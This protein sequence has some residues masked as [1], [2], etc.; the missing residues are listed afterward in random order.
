MDITE[1]LFAAFV[2]RLSD[3]LP[4]DR[5]SD[6]YLERVAFGTDASCYQ[7][8]PKLVLRLDDL[9]ELIQLVQVAGEFTIPLTF[10]AAGTSLSGQA[11]TDS[12]LVVLS[13]AWANL[14]VRD[15]GREIVLGPAVVGGDANR[16]LEKYARKIGPDPASINTAKMGGIAANNAS[17]MC[18]GTRDNAYNTLRSMKLVLANG[19]C[20]D[21]ACENSINDFRHHNAALLEGLLT[22]R[23]EIESNTRLREKIR[24]KYRIKNT[25]GYGLNALLDFDDPIDILQHLMI[26]S[27]GT[28]GFI[29]EI[30]LATVPDHP[31]KAAAL[32]LFN[33]VTDAARAVGV[34]KGQWVEAVELMDHH[35]LH[36]VKERLPDHYQSFVHHKAGD[37]AALLVVV[38]GETKAALV[39]RIEQIPST[40][41]GLLSPATFSVDPKEYDALWRIRKSILPIVGAKRPAGT[42][43]IIEDVAFPVENLAEAVAE[44]Q[45]L[46]ERCGYRD[47]VIFGH[48][49]A[50]NLHIV[51]TQSFANET[52]VQRYRQLMQSLADLVIG[53]YQGSMKAEHGTGRN[54]APFVRQEWGDDAYAIMTS[55]KA[56]LDPEKLL[57]PDVILSDDAEL[58]LRNLKHLPITDALVD[59][60]I[61]CGFC[62]PSCPSKNLTLSPRQR[63]SV[64]RQRVRLQN[65]AVAEDKK[66]LKKI[67]KDYQYAGLDTCAACGLCSIS[68]PVGINTGDLTRALRGKKNQRFVWLARGLARHIKW[69]GVL[70]RTMLRSASLLARLVG[71]ERLYRASHWMNKASGGVVPLWLPSLQTIKIV[72][73]EARPEVKNMPSSD[74][75]QDVLVVYFPACPNRF[76]PDA[77]AEHSPALGQVI[78][79]LAEQAGVELVSIPNAENYCCGMPFASK[80]F[81]D[82]ARETAEQCLQ[83]L[84]AAHPERS[85]LIVSDASPCASTLKSYQNTGLQVMDLVEFAHDYLLPTLPITPLDET[86]ML[87]V[88]CTTQV[89]GNAEKMLRVAQACAQ[90]V[91]RPLSVSCCGFAGDKGFTLPELNA[92]ALSQ[93]ANEVPADCSRGYSNSRTCELGL[94]QH[95][96]I[97]YEHLL[98]LLDR[99]CRRASL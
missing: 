99:A 95:S 39:N 60:C 26:G 59:D 71:A 96:G 31:Y 47:A 30:R 65:S 8:I 9:D 97:V 51:F 48:A 67:N 25:T 20:L 27:E 53:R 76:M 29:A 87:H 90:R 46:F 28:L 61:E 55:I 66:Q 86:V 62:E 79:R 43:V 3:F 22:L 49:L 36:S 80:G 77:L 57:N 58:H 24:Y 12:V 45:T 78:A 83:H 1:W 35:C 72:P 54:M 82:V 63:I 32:W 73:L 11:I 15:G 17:G 19:S 21:T 41:S 37:I 50:G 93:L 42:T 44:L 13:S 98:Y 68:C 69:L 88:T 4:P 85:L 64:Q 84:A 89:A 52:Q 10:R 14:E 91:V 23:R 38:R 74:I 94:T 33:S 92:M 34:L 16:A 2:E 75:D 81:A 18:C 6:N 40:F 5:R 56:L 7:L 70:T